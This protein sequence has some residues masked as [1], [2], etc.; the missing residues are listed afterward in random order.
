MVMRRNNFLIL[1]T[2]RFQTMD[3]MEAFHKSVNMII[4]KAN[5]NEFKKILLRG[6][7]ENEVFYNVFKTTAK[8]ILGN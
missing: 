5:I 1:L 2:S 6:I 4:N 8:K 3:N 7:A